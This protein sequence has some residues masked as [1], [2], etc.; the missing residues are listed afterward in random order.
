MQGLP[1]T[2]TTDAQLMRRI[3][4]GEEEALARL[5]DRYGG[6]VFT[7]ALRMCGRS[8]VAEEI[9]QDVFLT[10]WRRGATWDP[11]RGSVQAWLITIARNRCIDHLRSAQHPPPVPLPVDWA[12]N[13]AG[14]AELAERADAVRTVRRAV[15][16]LP[17]KLR[18]ALEIVYYGGLSHTQ[19]AAKLGIPAGT[20]KS[21]L[22]LAVERLARVLRKEEVGP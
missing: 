11:N 4:A 20:V 14:P 18:E 6:L 19:A 7:L 9:V 12:S 21:R 10:V 5:Y 2:D 13:G 15:T 17:D 1:A 3:Q 22:R 8:D 16:Q